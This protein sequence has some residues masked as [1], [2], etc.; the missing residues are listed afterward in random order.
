MMLTDCPLVGIATKLCDTVLNILSEA[1][2]YLKSMFVEL[3]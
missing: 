1:F 2:L 3:A